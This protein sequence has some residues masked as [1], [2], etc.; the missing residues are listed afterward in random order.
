M[1]V[2]VPAVAPPAH[3]QE[4]GCHSLTLGKTWLPHVPSWQ[5]W[6][7]EPQQPRAQAQPDQ[8]LGSGSPPLISSSR[9]WAADTG[10]WGGH[11]HEGPL[12]VEDKKQECPS[13]DGLF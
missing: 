9:A 13:S 2:D 1:C 5:P 7:Q 6:W 11:T 10:G 12:I 8:T 4:P 3:L